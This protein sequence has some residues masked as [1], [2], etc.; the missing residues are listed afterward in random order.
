MADVMQ[1]KDQKEFFE[2]DLH[3]LLYMPA[4]SSYP[5]FNSEMNF[6]LQCRWTTESVF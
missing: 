4:E 2:Y 1:I 5:V 3:T 6:E